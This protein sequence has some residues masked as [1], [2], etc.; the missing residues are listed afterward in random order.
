ML[1]F[2]SSLLG[3]YCQSFFHLVC[4]IY[5]YHYQYH[6]HY[7]YHYLYYHNLYHFHCYSLVIYS[8]RPK[9]A[10]REL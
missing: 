4:Y 6:H 10:I 1:F 9:Q 5:Y 2:L 3:K 7:H 8:L